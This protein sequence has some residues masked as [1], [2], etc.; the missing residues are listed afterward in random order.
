MVFS[1]KQFLF[2]VWT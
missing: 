2:L 1:C